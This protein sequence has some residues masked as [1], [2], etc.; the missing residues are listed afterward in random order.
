FFSSRRRHTRFSR[1]WSSDVCSSDLERDYL[2]EG[3]YAPRREDELVCPDLFL[4]QLVEIQDVTQRVRAAVPAGADETRIAAATDSARQA[5]VTDC[6]NTTDFQC[7][8]VSLFPGG[9]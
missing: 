6:E 3:F 7:Q 2:T 5:I 9:Q 1:D 4:D 8:V